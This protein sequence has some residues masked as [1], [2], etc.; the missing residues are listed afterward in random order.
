M[1]AHV[2]LFLFPRFPG[3]VRN[4]FPPAWMITITGSIFRSKLNV[5]I[6][7]QQKWRDSNKSTTQMLAVGAGIN[8]IMCPHAQCEVQNG[9]R[10]HQ[11]RSVCL[12]TAVWKQIYSSQNKAFKKFILNAEPLC[13][14]T[15][16]PGHMIAF[17]APPLQQ[18]Q[19]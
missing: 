15:G 19:I 1:S 9:R 12:I 5:S 11:Q 4:T 7:C 8:C 13:V 10:Q 2:G 17:G 6:R 16:W 18:H 3:I 14:A